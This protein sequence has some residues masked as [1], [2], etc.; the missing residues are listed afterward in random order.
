MMD[1][2]ADLAAVL[3]IFVFFAAC[4]GLVRLCDRL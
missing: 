1:V 4:Q 3:I 2:F